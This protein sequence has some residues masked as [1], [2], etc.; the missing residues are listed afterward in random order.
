MKIY[1]TQIPGFT[2]RET[3]EKDAELVFSFIHKLSIYEKMEDH[4]V[5]TPES[6]KQTVYHEHKADVLLAY[7]KDT[8]VGFILYHE[9]YSTFLGK[10]NM[11]IEDIYID[12][13][14]R[15]KGYGSEIFSVIKK[16]AE[17]KTY[18]RIDW[19]CLNWNASAIEFYKKM[20]ATP[21]DHW[22]LFRY[23]VPTK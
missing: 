3:T 19:V 16:I 9:N 5:A 7:E 2:L 21:L 20:G 10:A 6:I 11:Y 23:Q 22:I 8:P 18:G 15:K 14:Y 13:P 4:V 1:T 12:E 17:E